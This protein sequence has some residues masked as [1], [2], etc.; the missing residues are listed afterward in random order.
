MKKK[1]YDPNI[2]GNRMNLVCFISGSGTNYRE[3]VTRNPDHNYLVFTNRP[4]CAGIDIARKNG[5]E[6][7]ELSHVPYLKEA[8]KKY[9]AGNIPRNCPERLAFEQDVVRL[10]ETKLG[11]EPDLICLAGY[12]LWITDWMVELYYPRILNVHPGDTTRGYYGLH[13]IPTANAILA[14]DTELRSTLFIVDKGGDTGPVLMQ[15]IPV[16]IP[17]TLE[18]IESKGTTSLLEQLNRVTNFARAHKITTYDDLKINAR[19]ELL[20]MLENI[21]ILLQEML[22]VKGDWQIYPFVVYDLIAKGRIEVDDREIYLDGE[23]L[24]EHGYRLDE[25]L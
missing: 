9:G 18:D 5:H 8:R 11:K 12:D 25:H 20:D 22:K 21:C 7:I 14:G 10:L 15:S 16:N 6:V 2:S 24:P 1:I 4:G 23:K 19:K 17:Q 3:I 13:W